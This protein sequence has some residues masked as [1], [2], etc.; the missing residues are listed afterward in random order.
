MGPE[1]FPP[2]LPLTVVPDELD[3]IVVPNLLERILRSIMHAAA[4]VALVLASLLMLTFIRLGFNLGDAVERIN[5]P[6][7]GVTGCP[8]GDGECGG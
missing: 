8:A 1:D 5:N 7:P 2:P 6:D 4:I 3:A